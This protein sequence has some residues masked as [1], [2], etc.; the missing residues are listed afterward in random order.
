MAQ[1]PLVRRLV[2]RLSGRAS[3]LLAVMTVAMLFAVGGSFVVA[4]DRAIGSVL[5]AFGVLRAVLAIR[6][7]RRQDET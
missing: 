4:G 1:P 5:L 3:T 2:H 6:D 7:Y